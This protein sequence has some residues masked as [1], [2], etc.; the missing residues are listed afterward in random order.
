M[1]AFDIW[2]GV[3]KSFR[4]VPARGPGVTGERWIQQSLRTITS[5]RELAQRGKSLPAVTQY[6]ES[7]LPL[8]AALVHYQRGSV[9]ILDVGGAIGFTYYQALHG[10]PRPE[11]FEFHVVE[12]E[13]VCQAGKECFKNE[14]NIFFHSSLP[15]E[16]ELSFDVVHLGSSL[17]YIEK[18]ET[19]L[20]DLCRLEA[21]YFLFTDLPAGD[22]PTFATAQNYYESA[23]AAWFF[24]IDEVIAVMAGLGYQ[25]IFRS[26][27][28]AKILGEEVEEL[29]MGNFEKEYR[30]PHNCNLLFVQ[31]SYQAD[32]PQAQRGAVDLKAG[33]FKGSL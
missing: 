12:V 21:K 11:H 32:Q 29:P 25:L 8:V 4:E 5:Y 23:I 2:E 31:V 17:Q 1:M 20:S 19:M 28:I 3:Y 30:L 33:S 24:N 10:L 18:W 7:L 9:R 26:A 16:R 13:A 27:Y 22:I 6:R 15:K 14:R